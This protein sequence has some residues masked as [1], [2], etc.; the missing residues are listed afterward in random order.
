MEFKT[1]E[2]AQDY[3]LNLEKQL[4]EIKQAKEGV[5]TKLNETVQNLDKQKS[6]ID[7]LKIKNYEYFEQLSLD[8]SNTKNEGQNNTTTKEEENT[9]SLDEVINA[10]K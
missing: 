5:E 8:K 6:E 1:I 10:F 2:E 3:V 9:P 7:R 4:N